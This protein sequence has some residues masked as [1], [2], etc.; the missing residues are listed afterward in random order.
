MISDF[1][2]PILD[3]GKS[4]KQRSWLQWLNSSS[5][6]LKFKTCPEP[7]RRIENPKWVGIFAI[8]LTFAFGGAVAQAQQPKK[9]PRVGWLAADSHAPTRESFRQ[10]LRD[11]GY[12]EGQNMLIEWRFTEGKSDRFL[13]LADEL[14]RL[15]LDVIVAGNASAVKTLKRAT[16]TIPIVMASYAGD[17]VADGIVRSFARP[18]GNVTGVIPVAQELSGKRLELLKETLP[19][20]SRVGVIWDP[21]EA[22]TQTQ[23]KETQTVGRGLGLKL[24]PIEVRNPGELDKAMEAARR[25]RLGAIVVLRDQITYL[26]RKQIVALA[27]R[28]RLP[29]MYP[30]GEFVEDGGLMSYS[31]NNRAQYQRAAY[32]VDRILKGAKPA[33]LPVEQPT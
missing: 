20:V 26:L 33:D 31:G 1:R 12:V 18:G 9:V 11:L 29:G 19:K 23:W 15:K 16:T 32:Y 13:E 17:P 24:L 25:D 2:L 30:Q 22:G 27:E 10:G 8:A 28:N 6:N 21:D 7:S 3:W 4:M 14:V 5:D